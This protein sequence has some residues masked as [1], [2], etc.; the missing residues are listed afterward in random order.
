MVLDWIIVIL[1][2]GFVAV[3]HSYD[4]VKIYPNSGNIAALIVGLY[5]LKRTVPSVE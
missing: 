1:L 4:L 5:H 3:W 2:L